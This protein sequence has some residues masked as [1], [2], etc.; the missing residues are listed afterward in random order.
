M[1][2][3]E[4]PKKP[5]IGQATVVLIAANTEYEFRFPKNLSGFRMQCRDGTAFIYSFVKNVVGMAVPS[6]PYATVL[7]ND[8]L[9]LRNLNLDKET[10]IY[11]AGSAGKVVECSF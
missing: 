3:I 5:K 1:E 8:N 11:L 10:V 7:A 4:Q 9:Q 6:E 2:T